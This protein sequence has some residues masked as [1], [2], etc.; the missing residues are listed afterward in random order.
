[1]KSKVLQG[2]KFVD[3][4]ITG[5]YYFLQG[6]LVFRKTKQSQKTNKQTNKTKNCQRGLKQM[7]K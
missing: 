5:N 4:S 6:M 3:K 2:V 7:K 1:M